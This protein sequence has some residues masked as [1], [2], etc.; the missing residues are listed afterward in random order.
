MQRDALLT[1]EMELGNQNGV[2]VL[3]ENLRDD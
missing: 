1:G 2:T 3:F